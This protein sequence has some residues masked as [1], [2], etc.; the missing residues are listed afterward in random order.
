MKSKA[1]ASLDMTKRNYSVLWQLISPSIL[2]LA[3][4]MTGVALLRFGLRAGGYPVH[5]VG[6][7]VYLAIV[8]LMVVGLGFG[9]ARALASLNLTTV[10]ILFSLPAFA[11]LVFRAAL[12]V[13][14]ILGGAPY[15]PWDPGDVDLV[16]FYSLFFTLLWSV[17]GLLYG[18]YAYLFA[19]GAGQ[20]VVYFVGHALPHWFRFP[21]ANPLGVR[22]GILLVLFVFFGMA[23][24]AISLRN[25]LFGQKRPSLWPAVLLL[26][27]AGGWVLYQTI[28]WL[29]HNGMELGWTATIANAPRQVSA[30]AWDWTRP[31]AQTLVLV[32]IAAV[33]VA[34]IANWLTSRTKSSD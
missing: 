9:L 5:S 26:T 31:A 2:L 19:G 12:W 22:P 4:V 18:S 6:L 8:L 15:A 29:P 27:I 14:P 13:T 7:T 16:I 24:A 21:E 20:I 28:G 32:A 10:L 11:S 1:V 33:P 30:Q 23:A 34:G 3:H 25:Q 17:V